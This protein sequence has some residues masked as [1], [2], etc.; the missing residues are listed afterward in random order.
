MRRNKMGWQVFVLAAAAAALGGCGRTIETESEQVS[1][2]IVVGFSQ[3]GTESDW[4]VANSESMYATFTEEN[5]YDL[6]YDDAQQKQENQIAA[7]RTFILQG[8][9]YIV[10]APVI[11]DGWDEILAEAKDAGIPV[12]VMDRM[13]DIDDDALYTAW[14]GS[15]TY[16]EGETAAEWLEEYLKEK[17]RESEEISI[18]HVQGTAGATPQL[19][20][21]AG[22]DAGIAR[23]RN[24]T[25][26]G[27]VEGEF[28]QAKAYEEVAEFLKKDR[29]ID[30]IYCENDNSAFGAIQALDEAGITYGEDGEVI[31]ISF[32][33]TR[34]GLTACMEGKI[35]LNVECNPLQAPKVEEIIQTLEAGE[36]PEKDSY[37]EET[38]FTP[39]SLTPEMIEE[40][41]Y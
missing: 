24:W 5:G 13:V 18:L 23:N 27:R 28:I 20:R 38:Y 33:A 1:E 21:T 8:V 14:V 41:Q 15:D 6:L 3:L 26:A 12:I 30:V 29:D 16:W 19:G 25:L 9:D 39:D 34:A 10:L 40:R 11:E 17:G 4:R 31:I 36:T 7:I 32:D 22:L 35:N 37:V 2:N